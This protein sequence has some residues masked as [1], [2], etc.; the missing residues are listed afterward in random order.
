MI[1]EGND[2]SIIC[3]A[4]FQMWKHL[5]IGAPRRV[6]EP[7]SP[8]DYLA[9]S[10]FRRDYWAQ[11]SCRR[12]YKVFLSTKIPFSISWQRCSPR[13]QN[14]TFRGCQCKSFSSGEFPKPNVS[15]HQMY[16]PPN[17]LSTK[18]F[19]PLKLFSIC[20]KGQM[21]TISVEIVSAK[22]VVARPCQWMALLRI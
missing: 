21:E 16:F 19:F 10:P 6:L 2:I 15:V 18:C 3:F 9:T 8:T 4:S 13:E 11:D 12:H 14:I 22:K 5:Y 20:Q 1:A 7:P 17:V